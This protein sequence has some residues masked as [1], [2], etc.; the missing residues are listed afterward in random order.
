M[1]T[2]TRT[3]WQLARMAGCADPDAIDSPGAAFLRNVESATIEQCEYAGAWDPDDAHEIADGA[4]P[5]YTGDLWRTFTDLAAWV[6]DLDE[7]GGSSGG[8]MSADAALALYLI[9]SR[10]AYAVGDL[11]APDD[12]EHEA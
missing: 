6:E 9:A 4:V 8:D 1:A 10:L 5:V 12:D 7:A 11:W 3:P 2:E